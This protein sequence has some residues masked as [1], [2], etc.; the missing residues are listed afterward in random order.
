SLRRRLDYTRANASAPP[1]NRGRRDITPLAR[2]RFPSERPAAHAR[3]LLRSGLRLCRGVSGRLEGRRVSRPVLRT[4]LSVGGAFAGRLTCARIES[5][6]P[7]NRDLPK[8]RQCGADG[9]GG[10]PRALPAAL[11]DSRSLRFAR[12]NREHPLRLPKAGG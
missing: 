1:N 4:G 5:A 8:L 12:P 2:L 9:A 6:A 3:G 10:R 11:R 7:L